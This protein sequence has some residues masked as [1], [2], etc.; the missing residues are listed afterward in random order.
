M[1]RN[2]QWL[3]M[4]AAGWIACDA[5]P[6]FTSP[7][8]SEV[9]RHWAFERVLDFPPPAV[10]NQSWVR[11]PIDRFIL[12]KLEAQGLP[13]ASRA[14]PRSL[15]R[16]LHYGLTGLP[17]TA[18]EI[19]TFAAD[20]S[21]Q[22]LESVVDHL[23]ASPH[24][25]ERWGRH[26]LDV[27]RYADTKGYVYYYEE[28]Q[29]V[30][31]YH[32]RDWVVRSLNQDLPYDR[33]LMLQIA[34]DHLLASE[35]GAPASE[36]VS[37]LRWPPPVFP[38]DIAA[39]GFLTLGRRFLDQAHDIIDDQIDVVMRGTLALT[40]GCARCHD[41]KFDPIPTQD[42]YS[43]YG[44]FQSSEERIVSLHAPPKP[45]QL[46]PFAEAKA[47]LDFERGLTERVQRLEAGYKKAV[48]E[49]T[50]RLRLRVK[51][52]LIAVLDVAKLP[53]DANVR[54]QPEDI[55]PF[56]VRQWE[57]YLSRHASTN[58]PIFSPWHAFMRLDE[59][60]YSRDA[61]S[62]SRAFYANGGA[63]WNP[64]VAQLFVTPP[65]NRLDLASRYG[66]L[67]VQAHRTIKSNRVS[68]T[69]GAAAGT[70]PSGSVASDP[71]ASVLYGADSPLLPPPGQITELDVHL[72]FDDP[73]RVALTKMQMEVEQ[74]LIGHQA[75][76]AYSLVLQ[77]RRT[78]ISPVVF[79]RGDPMKHGETVPR[80]FLRALSPQAPEPFK[81]GSG[82]LELAKAI[83]NADNPLTARVIVNRVWA[84]H[85][86]RGLVDTPSDFGTR[87]AP[88]S[89]PELL[90]WLAR[91][92]I[93]DGW[94]L[95]ALHRLILTSSVY[96]Q[97]AEPLGTLAQGARARD[98][99]NRM[100]WHFSRQRLD[101]ESLRDSLLSA[102][103]ELD[104]TLGGPGADLGSRPY[105]KRRA[106]YGLID[107]KFLSTDARSFDFANPDMH[108][109]KRHVTAVP[110]QALFLL[111]SPFVAERCRALAK[112]ILPPSGDAGK[113]PGSLVGAVQRLYLLT[114]QRL[115]TSMEEDRAS[116][117][118][119]ES[120]SDP[121]PAA[122]P[123][124]R[125]TPWEQLAQVLVFCNDF[126][127]ID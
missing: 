17:P 44:V 89:H 124:L 23:L 33:F 118:L 31:P 61:A 14:V 127:Y 108:S 67:F 53:T 18:E 83:A 119:S 76:A 71:L 102:S 114:L 32:Y 47:Y 58:D 50:E 116:L 68:K 27:A 80:Q 36:G 60:Q 24:Y 52:Y 40:V 96:Q 126:L 51:D 6:A 30:Q 65:T 8:S 54:P 46:L 63:R 2:V 92:F 85:F 79:R 117:F 57:R 19:Q 43:L 64:E 22:A 111:N 81:Q 106:I 87:S 10:T 101:F 104:P 45:D 38:S 5:S 77:D 29:F 125:L 88:P 39:L 98:P 100:L 97:S 69:S 105:P 121:E 12:A 112:R 4:L 11:T 78:P 3:V 94:S 20:P 7:I 21:P 122:V 26:W 73:N 34:A 107:R 95:K 37:T 41:H 56:N 113:D 74:W 99:E 93:A 42:Y 66:D 72:Y 62:L 82:R 109:P 90:D 15:I 48:D 123:G 115:P 86:G 49:V 120:Q 13:P 35:P 91:R 9:R 25:G 75:T 1:M 16:R 103:G 110:Q 55:N 28:S 84:Q 70:Q 59:S